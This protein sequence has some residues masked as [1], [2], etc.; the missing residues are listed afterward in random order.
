MR[1]YSNNGEIALGIPFFEKEIRL[2]FFAEIYDDCGNLGVF[3][4]NVYRAAILLAYHA[5]RK[6]ARGYGRGAFAFGVQ[7]S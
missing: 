4:D 3:S 7:L 2:A 6:I 1:A 5:C